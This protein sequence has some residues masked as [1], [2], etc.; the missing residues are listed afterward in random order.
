MPRDGT[1]MMLQDKGFSFLKW[2]F[3]IDFVMDSF[4]GTFRATPFCTCARLLL[5]RRFFFII[6][7]WRF[8][9]CY[10]LN[11]VSGSIMEPS[12]G[13]LTFCSLYACKRLLPP[14]PLHND[15]HKGVNLSFFLLYLT[16]ISWLQLSFFYSI[17]QKEITISKFS[18]N[19]TLSPVFFCLNFYK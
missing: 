14:P 3:A 9:A 10:Q 8:L 17:L 16:A 12:H 2:G 4:L 6:L 18:C 15:W 11:K 19:I 7:Y 5:R 13:R 1:L